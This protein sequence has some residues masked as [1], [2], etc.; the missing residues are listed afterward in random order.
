MRETE[1]MSN[2][3]QTVLLFAAVIGGLSGWAAIAAWWY[4]ERTKTVRAIKDLRRTNARLQKAVVFTLDKWRD[5]VEHNQLFLAIEQEYA[6]R[7]AREAGVSPQAVKATMR[8]SVEQAVRNG[9][10]LKTD[11]A[12]ASRVRHQLAAIEDVERFVETGEGVLAEFE[13]TDAFRNAA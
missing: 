8:A 7:L 10:P 2:T 9:D 13:I 6:E 3:L 11:P 12:N 1:S 4:R 5:Q